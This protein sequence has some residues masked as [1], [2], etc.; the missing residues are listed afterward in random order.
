MT[1]CRSFRSG[2]PTTD[3]VVTYTRG[4]DLSSSLSGAEGIG[5]MLAR[6]T[7]N[8]SVYYHSDALGSITALID[9]NQNI[10]A[11][12]E[13]DGAGRLINKTGSTSDANLHRLFSKQ[14][15]P[16]PDEYDFGWRK[17][18]PTLQRFTSQDP[19]QEAGGF[20]LYQ[21]MGNN[22]VNYID[23]LGD[24]SYK[25]WTWFRSPPTPSLP[26]NPYSY[27][28]MR[29]AMIGDPSDYDFGGKTAGQVTQDIGMAV[30][31]GILN[32]VGI[33]GVGEAEGAYA[34]ADEA[35]Q[36]AR[37]AKAAKVAAKALEKR[38]INNAGKLADRLGKS[39]AEVND[40]IHA[41]KKSLQR[42]KG[43]GMKGNVNV[44]IDPST[45]EAYPI[46]PGGGL[47]DSIGNIF[48]YLP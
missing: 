33:M 16:N 23:P 11:R 45:G 3:P 26:S 38:C 9:G 24:V 29:D 19:L 34:A 7:A 10:V 21:A 44:T 47:G 14:Y 31:K 28:A 37:A 8:G 13:Y 27:K 30:P 18:T 12:Y 1:G 4:L 46:I 39:R 32:A 17:Y 25:P 35:L 43:K 40:A 36:A 22:A 6:T 20:N 41:V 48:D 15:L 2:T 42:F 5:G